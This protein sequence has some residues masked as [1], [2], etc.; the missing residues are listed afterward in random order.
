[1]I[2]LLIISL[3]LKV[4]QSIDAYIAQNN[5]SEA[6][7]QENIHLPKYEPTAVTLNINIAAYILATDQL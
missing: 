3:K 7:V 5:R 4:E 2:Q 6:I 1:M